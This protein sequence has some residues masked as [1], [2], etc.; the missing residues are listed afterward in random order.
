MSQFATRTR[1][2]PTST[3]PPSREPSTPNRSNTR[4][5]AP[6]AYTPKRA[7]PATLTSVNSS[8]PCPPTARPPAPVSTA[9]PP[10]PVNRIGRPGAPSR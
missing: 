2:V 9:V 1:R 5:W 6:S 10:T 3:S 8:Q 4:S 7:E